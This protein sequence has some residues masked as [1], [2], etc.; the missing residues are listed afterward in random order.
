MDLLHLF[1]RKD[2]QILSREDLISMDDAALRV[3]VDKEMEIIKRKR[4]ELEKQSKKH[5][6]R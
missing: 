3:A 4:K 2:G 5:Q 6:S 1:N